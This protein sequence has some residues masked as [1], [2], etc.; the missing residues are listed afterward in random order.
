MTSTKGLTHFFGFE[1]KRRRSSGLM[2]RFG[3]GSRW[4]VVDELYERAGLE[5]LC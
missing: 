4:R 3:A 1:K 2:E 5:L